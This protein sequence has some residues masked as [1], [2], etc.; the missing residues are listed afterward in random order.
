MN[1][2]IALLIFL[3]FCL[4]SYIAVALMLVWSHDREAAMMEREW[5]AEHYEK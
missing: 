5:Q 2:L 4:C 3:A 1:I